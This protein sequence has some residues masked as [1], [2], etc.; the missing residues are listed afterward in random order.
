MSLYKETK[1]LLSFPY[2]KDY[3]DFIHKLFV[4]LKTRYFFEDI[5]LFS[6][7]TLDQEVVIGSKDLA[8]LEEG[9]VLLIDNKGQSI[10]RKKVL[11]SPKKLKYIL[12]PVYS[13]TSIEEVIAIESKGI[14]NFFEGMELEFIQFLNILSDFVSRN[15]EVYILKKSKEVLKEEKI[16]IGQISKP[17]VSTIVEEVKA[18]TQQPATTEDKTVLE[19]KISA[20]DA[21]NLTSELEAMEKD[22]IFK[23]LKKVNGNRAEAS[24]KLGLTERMMGYKVDKYEIDWKALRK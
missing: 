10:K 17:V 15:K 6:F 8:K 13:Q 18:K 19:K 14:P 7:S 5:K 2:L 12:L 21:I 1:R 11:S 23:I 3:K 16:I 9:K 20:G 4:F 24:R 22:I